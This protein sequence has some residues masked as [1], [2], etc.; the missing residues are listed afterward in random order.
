MQPSKRSSAIRRATVG[1]CRPSSA[2]P[3]YFG[4][5]P[6]LERSGYEVRYKELESGHTAPPEI[7]REVVDWFVA[8]QGRQA[9]KNR[10][11]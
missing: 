4:L 2:V 10:T 5:V 1:F 11:G 9:N 7:T 6:R 8:E 3:A